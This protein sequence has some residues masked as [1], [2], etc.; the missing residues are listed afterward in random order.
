MKNLTQKT[1]QIG[2]TLEKDSEQ[3]NN[4]G[5]LF[6]GVHDKYQNR[7]SSVKYYR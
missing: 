2:Y 6:E 1:T 5:I 4:N 7:R 3:A